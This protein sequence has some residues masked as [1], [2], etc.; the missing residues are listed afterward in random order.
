MDT[1]D[2][3][4]FAAESCSYRLVALVTQHTFLLVVGEVS[5]VTDTQR[6][7]DVSRLEVRAL[8][9]LRV[10]LKDIRVTV[11]VKGQS[12]AGN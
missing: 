9:S 10:C 2:K 7:A 3:D 1:E 11:E 6:S 12:R 5:S 8:H 4:Q